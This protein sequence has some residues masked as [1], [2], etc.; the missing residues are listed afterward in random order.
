[1]REWR[2]DRG[3]GAERRSCEG[4]EDEDGNSGDRNHGGIANRG[5]SGFVVAKA[6]FQI[7]ASLITSRTLMIDWKSASEDPRRMAAWSG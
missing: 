7:P 5:Y 6:T 3:L 4:Q 1:M 2:G